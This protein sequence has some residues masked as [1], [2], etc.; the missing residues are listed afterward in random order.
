MHNHWRIL[1]PPRGNSAIISD[2]FKPIRFAG[3]A[4]SHGMARGSAYGY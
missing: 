3:N 2:Y 4:H 1:K